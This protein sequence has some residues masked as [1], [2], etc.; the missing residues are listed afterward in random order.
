MGPEGAPA[1]LHREGRVPQAARGGAR[2]ARRR[3][4][5]PALR[6][7]P[8]AAGGQERRRR[9]HRDARPLARDH[10]DRRD[11]RGQGRLLR[12]AA[13]GDGRGGAAHGGG[14][15]GEPAGVLHGPQ[16]PWVRA[17][18]APQEGDRDGQVRDVP[19]G[20]RRAQ[21]EHLPERPRGVPPLRAAEGLQLGRLA[22]AARVP[23]LQVHD[24]ALLLPL[25][26]GLFEPGRQLGRPLP[27]RDALDDGRD[28]AR[29][30]PW[31]GSTSRASAATARSPTR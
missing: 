6:G 17:L 5:V 19:H 1:V 14:G 2:R 3:R 7:L 26:P 28:G 9:L 20:A 15:E 11:L 18:P 24:G 8:Q 4:A 13:H 30:P 21:L 22:R 23:S 16:P 25:A 31:A 27:R 29:S 12:E 10:D